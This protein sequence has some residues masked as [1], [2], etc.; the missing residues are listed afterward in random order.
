MSAQVTR[1][2]NGLRVVTH[3]MPHLKTASLGV[4]VDQGAR[5]EADS[6]HG[7]SHLLEHMAFK[8]TARRSARAIAEE[9]ES[10]GGDLNAATGFEQ[11]AYYARVLKED[12]PLAIDI[13]GDILCDSTF[14]EAE[15][16][17]EQGVVV[18][19]IRA[20]NDTPDD[21]VFDRFQEAAFPGQAIGRSILGTPET[22][23]GFRRDHL[24][25][26]LN[27]RYRGPGTILAAA[28][29]V[30]HAEVVRLA[31]D[32]LGAFGVE[33]APP[34]AAA[35]YAGGETRLERDL[36][37][38]HLVIGMQG[39]SYLDERFYAAQMLANILGGG[40]SSR[41]FQEIR[42]KRGLCY[43]ISAFHWTFRDVGLF[44][45]YAA[46]GPDELAEL[47]PAVAGEMR[48][49]AAGITEEEAARARAQLKA[50]LMMSL[51]SSAARAEQIARQEMLFGRVIPIDEMVA[52][53]ESVT[54]QDLRDVAAGMLAGADVTVSAVGPLRH[55]ARYDEIA[56]RFR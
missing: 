18:Q 40:M 33:A 12:V 43:A 6:E 53:V 15:L 48:E 32:R 19:E 21:I 26:Y 51:E 13:L 22:V 11:T 7:I 5:S 36:E 17:R 20:V 37:Q 52:R 14:D 38:A 16:A 56:G 29:A 54:A 46:T 39:M 42:E 31:E 25:G 1:L 3:E 10:V 2:E 27:A 44:G 41:L 9:I 23:R 55:L 24:H 34:V 28:G 45:V 8:G 30:D 50:G 49:A 35:R 47:V 4:W